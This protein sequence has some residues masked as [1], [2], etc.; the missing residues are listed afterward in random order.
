[1]DRR[2]A[3]PYQDDSYS[4]ERAR[5]FE[6]KSLD[7]MKPVKAVS[8]EDLEAMQ[9]KK[10]EQCYICKVWCVSPKVGWLD[11]Y[12]TRPV[13]PECWDKLEVFDDPKQNE[14]DC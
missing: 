3:E 6:Q 5:V 10:L 12:H 9:P 8:A 4:W 1:M 7:L 13:C 14:T 2:L 11:R